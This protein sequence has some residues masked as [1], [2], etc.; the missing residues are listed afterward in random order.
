MQL[1]NDHQTIESL[2]RER[3]FFCHLSM[4]CIQKPTMLQNIIN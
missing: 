4:E 2:N 3:T 1:V